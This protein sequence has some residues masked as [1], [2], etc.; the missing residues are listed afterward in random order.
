MTNTICIQNRLN[1]I[2]WTKALA[3]SFVVFGHIPQIRGSF[4]V[5]FITQFHIPLFFFISGYLT[6]KEYMNKQT[7]NKYF[8]S[9][10]IPYLCY[11]L[12]FYPYWVVRYL[13]ESP[14][15]YWYDFLKPLIGTVML[16]HSSPYYESLNGV[17]WFISALLIMKCILALTNYLRHGKFVV[18]LVVLCTATLYAVNEY[19]RYVIDLPFVGFIR[20]FPFFVLGHFCRQKNYLPENTNMR[21]DLFMTILS[22]SAS[23]MIFY[24]FHP[25]NITSYTIYFWCIN[26]TAIM[27]IISLCRLMNNHM[28]SFILNISIGTLVVMGMH[29][30]LIGLTNYSLE[31]ILKVSDGNGYPWYIAILLTILFEAILYPMIILFSKKYPVMIGKKGRRPMDII[32]QGKDS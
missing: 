15:H 6:K 11:N 5:C 16:Q 14:N 26:L 24:F 31:S 30:M 20:C 32:V 17:T 25:Y 9:L 1:W 19:E 22:L 28:N 23:L 21:K 4:P 3:I 2:D 27:G 29:W 10:I 18:F 7:A 12:I 13:I 8:H